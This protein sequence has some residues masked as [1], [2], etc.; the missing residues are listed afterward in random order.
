MSI[1]SELQ[2]FRASN[3]AC[4]CLLHFQRD[5]ESFS[6]PATLRGVCL[7]SLPTLAAFAEAR[8][9]CLGTVACCCL[10]R[11]L[12]R[13]SR[14]PADVFRCHFV[15]V[16]AYIPLACVFKHP[17]TQIKTYHV[18]ES[19]LCKTQRHTHDSSMH[20]NKDLH[21]HDSR[22]W[23]AQDT[24]THAQAHSTQMRKHA[25]QRLA[26][27]RCKRQTKTTLPQERLTRH[28]HKDIGTR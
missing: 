26:R 17:C 13:S 6:Y 7:P 18:R 25:A 19:R 2:S 28:T 21:A 5:C 1:H 12:H 24:H 8:C 14:T 10:V 23:H 22:T 3:A 16:D 9:T 4:V 11:L 27:D 15:F 20:S